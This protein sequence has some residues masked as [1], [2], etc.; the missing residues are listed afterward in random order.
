MNHATDDAIL[1]MTKQQLLAI[2]QAQSRIIAHNPSLEQLMTQ[3]AQLAQTLTYADGAAV[4]LEEGQYM[5]YRAA[6]GKAADQLGV[7]LDKGNS[8][9]GLCLEQHQV[10]YCEDALTDPRVDRQACEQV[11]LRSMLVSPLHY[12]EQCFGVLKVFSPKPSAFDEVDIQVLSLVAQVVAA[13]VHAS[14]AKATTD[15]PK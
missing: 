14:L 7:R 1:S 3:M 8:L 2:I 6:T 5:V 10:L 9:S 13:A 12:A 15:A 4:E 11:G